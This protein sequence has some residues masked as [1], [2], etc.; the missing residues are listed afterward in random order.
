MAN[1]LQQMPFLEGEELLYVQELI[2]D[3]DESRAQQFASVYSSRRK[4]PTTIMILTLL[5]FLG[6]AGIQ[7]FILDQIG[8]G[9][10]YFLTAG[11]CLIGT[12]IDLVNYRKLAFEYNS[13]QAQQVASLVKNFSQN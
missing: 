13:R 11:L 10:L 2:K 12:I 5:G 3:F 4:D 8:M 1:I 7:R 9:I 6:I